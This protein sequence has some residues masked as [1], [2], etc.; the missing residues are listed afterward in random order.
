M[1]LSSRIVA[2]VVCVAAAGALVAAQATPLN[3]KLGLWE[4]TMN[5]D[6]GAA[7]PGVDTSKMTPEQQQQM[8][9]IMRSRGMPAMT[10]KTCMTR[11][12]LAENRLTADREGTTCRSTVVKATATAID[13]N[14]V[15]TG[16][17]PSTSEIHVEAPTPTSMKTTMKPTSGRGAGM[18]VT[19]TSKWLQ[20]DCGD[21]K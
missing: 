1:T 20:T 17:A 19:M 13:L 12:K 11:E 5:M 8:A 2:L 14:Q 3:V 16:A 6:M 4:I 10:Q 9:A 7:P 18:T 21:I 15:C